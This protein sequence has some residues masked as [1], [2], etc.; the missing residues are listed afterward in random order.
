MTDDEEPPSTRR[1]RPRERGQGQRRNRVNLRLS[2]AEHD[3]LET[4]AAQSGTTLA[5]YVS[6]A[7]LSA[8]RDELPPDAR[9]AM[10]RL[11]AMQRAVVN[12]C[13]EQDSSYDWR[14]SRLYA[15]CEET[16]EEF[17]NISRRAR[18]TRAR[19]TPSRIQRAN[20]A[21]RLPST[22]GEWTDQ[23]AK[24]VR[25]LEDG[26]PLAQ[27]HWNHGYLYSALTDAVIALGKANPGGLNRLRVIDRLAGR[28]QDPGRWPPR[29][30]PRAQRF[31][32]GAAAARRRAQSGD[33]DPGAA[34]AHV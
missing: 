28:T 13:T 15:M 14:I 18:G 24:F 32:A 2:D 30:P 10:I 26:G 27:E 23:L 5:N 9:E 22:A 12:L 29:P 8:A 19:W 21:P 6:A 20:A 7:A 1:R 16:I 33:D 34:G 25:Q 11:F 4:A 17:I 31:G 3:A